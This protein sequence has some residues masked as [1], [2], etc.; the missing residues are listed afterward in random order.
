[1]RKLVAVLF[2]IVRNF[3]SAQDCSFK[4]DTVFIPT[5]KKVMDSEYLE[6]TLKNKSVFKLVKAPNKKLYVKFIVTENLYFGKVD[7]LEIRSGKRSFYVKD[8]MHYQYDKYKGYYF[9][10][11]YPNYV[12]TLR[13][14]GL[15]GIKFGKAETD[16]GKT[17][18]NQVKLISKCFYESIAP[19]K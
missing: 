10:E 18:C 5:E 19:K 9:F 2:L 8:A 14:D 17:D 1:M 7:Q 15:T 3:V 12:I 16:F 4:S 11:I 13:D 6:A